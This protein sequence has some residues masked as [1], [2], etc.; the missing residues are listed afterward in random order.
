MILVGY[1]TRGGYKLYDPTNKQVV[2]NKDVMVDEIKEWN[3]N[4][5]EK[6][7][8]TKILLDYETTDREKAQIERTMTMIETI[9]QEETSKP[10]HLKGMKN[11]RWIA[12][13]KEKLND[14]LRKIKHESPLIYQLKRKQ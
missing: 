3:W 13:M 5:K 7:N 11:T 4:T 2:I 8:S 14:Q 9:G 6:K 1:H 12:A 10:K